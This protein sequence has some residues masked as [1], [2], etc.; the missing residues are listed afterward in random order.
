MLFLGFGV[1]SDNDHIDQFCAAARHA[2][3][4][5]K[6]SA[7]PC[8]ISSALWAFLHLVYGSIRIVACTCDMAHNHELFY[9]FAGEAV[10]RMAMNAPSVDKGVG[11]GHSSANSYSVQPPLPFES[12]WHSSQAA[13]QEPACDSASASRTASGVSFMSTSACSDA[14]DSSVDGS[15]SEEDGGTIGQKR[16]QPA[17]SA[18][19]ASDP[20]IAFGT[21]QPS[22]APAPSAFTVSQVPF[23]RK[24]RWKTLRCTHHSLQCPKAVQ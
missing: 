2:K 23:S 1:M 24:A 11:Q 3:R 21:S 18:M 9:G 6:P 4:H 20:G 16:P 5:V 17:G 10:R 13:S 8:T 15:G 12:A 7:F 22:A 19:P 14:E